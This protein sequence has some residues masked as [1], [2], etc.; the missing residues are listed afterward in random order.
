MHLN[1][2]NPKKSD[3][4]PNLLRECVGFLVVLSTLHHASKGNGRLQKPDTKMYRYITP[5]MPDQSL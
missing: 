4:K 2:A 1:P 3:T 5:T